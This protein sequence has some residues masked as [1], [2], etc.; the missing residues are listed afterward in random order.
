MEQLEKARQ[1][2]ESVLSGKIKANDA[3]EITQHWLQLSVYDLAH[4]VANRPD[5]QSRAD[6]LK[7]ILED[8][9][10]FYDDVKSMAKQIY[11]GIK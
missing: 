6:A 8:S 11:S 4:S 2:L 9:P 3:C 5:K 7:T 10:E 1:D